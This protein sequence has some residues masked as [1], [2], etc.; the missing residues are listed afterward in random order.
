MPSAAAGTKLQPSR[1]CRT[2][3]QQM[4]AAVCGTSHLPARCG[5][6][7]PRRTMPRSWRSWWRSCWGCGLRQTPPWPSVCS[8]WPWQGWSMGSRCGSPCG[9]EQ[10][11]RTWEGTGNTCNT[12]GMLQVTGAAASTLSEPCRAALPSNTTPAHLSPSL[13]PSCEW[14]DYSPSL[15]LRAVATSMFLLVLIKK[16]SPR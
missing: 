16:G 13:L 7:G 5:W 2:R 11:G 4:E 6:A 8:S 14:L 1:V 12:G 3:P 10:R 9:W 15:P